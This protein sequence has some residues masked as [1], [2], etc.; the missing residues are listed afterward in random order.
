MERA[1]LVVLDALRKGSEVIEQA[2]G[3]EAYDRAA[4]SK[5][6]PVD[7]IV[8]TMKAAMRPELVEF[9]ARGVE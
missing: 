1:N 8:R 2:G 5:S 6:L 4:R 3:L 7:E 9:E